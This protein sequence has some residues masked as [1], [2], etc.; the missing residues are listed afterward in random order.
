MKFLLSDYLVTDEFWSEIL[1]MFLG[2]EAYTNTNLLFWPFPQKLHGIEKKR[3]H[4][5]VPSAHLTRWR[6]S[7]QFRRICLFTLV[8]IQEIYILSDRQ[9][10]S[11]QTNTYIFS[12]EVEMVEILTD[13][14][15]K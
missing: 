11:L 13:L 2:M 1:G 6:K 12:L 10:T 4:G 15:W 7:A 8:S 3:L 5:S 9:E 14:N